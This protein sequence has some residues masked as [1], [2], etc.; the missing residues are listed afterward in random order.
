MIAAPDLATRTIDP[1]D[2]LA[3]LAGDL[4][5]RFVQGPRDLRIRLEQVDEACD[6]DGRFRVTKFFCHD[7]TWMPALAELLARSDVV[8]MDLRSFSES[9]R[10]CIVELTQLALQKRLGRTLFVV[11]GTTDLSLLEATVHRETPESAA[12]PVLNCERVETGRATEHARVYRS[13]KKLS[14]SDS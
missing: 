6:P 7:N 10:G 2:T 13:L 4:R 12:A 9:N 11:D 5:S 8:L 3:V 1:D 14:H